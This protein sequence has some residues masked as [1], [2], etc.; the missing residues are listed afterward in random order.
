MV[1]RHKTTN[2]YIPGYNIME[3]A[4]SVVTWNSHQKAK[5]TAVKLSRT[6]KLFTTNLCKI[7]ISSKVL[8]R[9]SRLMPQTYTTI[10]L[11]SKPFYHSDFL[12]DTLAYEI[13][14]M[15]QKRNEKVFLVIPPQS[16][17]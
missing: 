12:E 13:G 5:T 10:A 16:N 7:I 4:K 8:D 11:P 14:L 1:S 2:T 17:V 9:N 6:L 3:T 15:F